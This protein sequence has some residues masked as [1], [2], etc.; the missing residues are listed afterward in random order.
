MT[1]NGNFR[2]LEKMRRNYEQ[3]KY[4]LEKATK[5]FHDTATS[6]QSEIIQG[7]TTGDEIKD[8]A[9]MQSQG[10]YPL[11]LENIQKIDA[12]LKGEKGELIGYFEDFYVP[13]SDHVRKGVIGRIGD[14]QISIKSYDRGESYLCIRGRE[15]KFRD[16]NSGTYDCEVCLPSDS[17]IASLKD[18]YRPFSDGTIY[19]AR[20]VKSRIRVEEFAVIGHAENCQY[21][22]R[23]GAENILRFA[24]H[25]LWNWYA[26]E[27]RDTPDI[28]KEMAGIKH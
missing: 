18:E 27:H 8:W 1:L 9:I 2:K 11:L 25:F 23:V 7:D 14:P 26:P 19:P 21:Q 28:V 4:T 12:F 20:I 10:G 13:S 16:R 6:V 5:E 17:D 3:A 24:D 22:L 15:S